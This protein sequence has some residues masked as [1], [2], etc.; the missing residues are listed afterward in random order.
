MEPGAHSGKFTRK[1]CKSIL[2]KVA[3]ELIPT[4]LTLPKVPP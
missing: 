4:N 2:S 1:G 3:T